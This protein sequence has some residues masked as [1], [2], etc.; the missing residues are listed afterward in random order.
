MARECR[1]PR[2]A[3]GFNQPNGTGTEGRTPDRSKPSI[4][5]IHVIGSDNKAA[6]ECIKL[7]MD[8][9]K[10]H[11]LA[12]LVDTGADISLI[13]PDNLDKTKKIRPRR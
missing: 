8:I 5:A 7:R 1:K 11:E 13:K 4:G 3:K 9:S 10:G 2:T 12:L 6:T